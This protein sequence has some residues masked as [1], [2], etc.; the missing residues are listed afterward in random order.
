MGANLSHSD[1]KAPAPPREGAV[2]AGAWMVLSRL[3]ARCIDFLSLLVLGDL[4][5]T[6]DFGLVAMAMVL[7]QVVEAILELPVV[8]ALLNA[9]HVSKQML[10]TAFTLGVIR[11]A[12]I[13]LLV[14]GLAHPLAAF[15]GDPRLIPLVQV[16]ACAPMFRGLISPRMVFFQRDMDFRVEAKLEVFAKFLSFVVG[17]AVARTT[18]SYWAL[19]CVTCTTPIALAG[20]SF[21]VAPYRP[22]LSLAEWPRFAGILGWSSVMQTLRTANWQLDKFLLGRFVGPA[23]LGNYFMASNLAAVPNQAL[24]LP[25][26]RPIMAG[27]ARLTSEAELRRAYLVACSSIFVVAAPMMVVIALLAEPLVHIALDAKWQGVPALLCWLVLGVLPNLPAEPMVGLAIL[28]NQ[29]GYAAIRTAI[30]FL[31]RTPALLASIYY[32]GVQG[33]LVVNAITSVVN[34]VTTFYIARR[35][36]GLSLR[37]QLAALLRPLL[38]LIPSSVFLLACRTPLQSLPGGAFLSLL[39]L[40]ASLVALVIYYGSLIGLWLLVNRPTGPEDYIFALFLRCVRRADHHPGDE[41]Q[42]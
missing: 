21:V 2:A 25:V 7:V 32:L 15:Y 40:A 1:D 14:F 6:A 24:T 3:V 13:A 27:L 29:T 19:A 39:T 16:L 10:D 35:L 18:H 9:P 41:K 34:L 26:A 38:A 36:I 37:S 8:Q 4:L 12:T 30:V 33:A 11:A 42:E 17:Y 22:R 28:K 20:S 23:L 31:V 5:A